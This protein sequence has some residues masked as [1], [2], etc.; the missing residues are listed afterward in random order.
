MILNE[1]DFTK[2]SKF[3]YLDGK[4]YVRV[5]EIISVMANEE[6]NDWRAKKG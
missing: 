6:V 1:V 4:R 2:D 5:T 3:Y